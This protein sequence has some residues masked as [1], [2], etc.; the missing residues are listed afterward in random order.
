MGLAVAVEKREQIPLGP[1]C[2]CHAAPPLTGRRTVT[3]LTPVVFQI[4][5]SA[6]RI[7]TGS[8]EAGTL[9]GLRTCLPGFSGGPGAER[10]TT[11]LPRN[12]RG[13]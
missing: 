11:L 13:R 1:C 10:I 2:L 8:A 7:S 6:G 3:P 12:D 4:E 9:Y 5:G